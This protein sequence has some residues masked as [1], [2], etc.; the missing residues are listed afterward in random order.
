MSPFKCPRSFWL[1]LSGKNTSTVKW[2]LICDDTIVKSLCFVW[3]IQ[4]QHLF[5]S[6]DS[7]WI[8]ANW[9]EN[10]KETQH[11]ASLGIQNIIECN[12]NH[13]DFFSCA[14]LFSSEIQFCEKWNLLTVVLPFLLKDYNDWSFY[15]WLWMGFYSVKWY[16]TSLFILSHPVSLN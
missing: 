15:K 14:R 16:W 1:L 10:P 5:Y 4:T 2:K 6:G 8:R 9:T 3:A 13:I 7:F 12:G 11:I